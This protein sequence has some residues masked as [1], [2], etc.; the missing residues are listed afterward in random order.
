MF[1]GARQGG[2]PGRPGADDDKRVMEER[3]MKV[4]FRLMN[5]WDAYLHKAVHYGFI[6]AVFTYG[7]VAAGEWSWNPA[8]LVGKIFVA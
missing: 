7:L 1:R 5:L 4:I 2:P 3:A 8:T 6:P